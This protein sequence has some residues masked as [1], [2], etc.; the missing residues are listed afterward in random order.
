MVTEILQLDVGKEGAWGQN[1]V[2]LC[3]RHIEESELSEGMTKMN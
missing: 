1:P 2:G 3:G